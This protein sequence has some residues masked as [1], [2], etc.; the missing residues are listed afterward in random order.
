MEGPA[1]SLPGTHTNPF[2][3]Y[4]ADLK[5]VRLLPLRALLF[6]TATFRPPKADSFYPRGDLQKRFCLEKK[7]FCQL[8]ALQGVR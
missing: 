4:V 2:S 1:V 3:P 6:A 8:T 5:Q 7:R